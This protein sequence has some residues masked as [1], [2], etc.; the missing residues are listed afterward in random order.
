MN[1]NNPSHHPQHP[2][3]ARLAE[4]ASGFIDQTATPEEIDELDFLLRDSEANR[5]FF[6]QYMDVQAA[7]PEVLAET[8][9][10][11]TDARNPAFDWAST[12]AQ[13]AESRKT[14]GAI[15]IAGHGMEPP[16]RVSNLAPWL[17][18]IASLA[19]SCLFA[20]SF[21]LTRDINLVTTQTVR[22]SHTPEHRELVRLTSVADAELFDESVPAI[23]ASLKYGHEYALVT[24]I[25]SLTFPC[26]AEVI[27]EAPSVVEITD[28]M[29]LLIKA[30]KCS[31][32]APDGAEGFRVDTPDN[33]I[34][35]LGTRFAV[36]VS[37]AGRTDVHVVEGAAEISSLASPEND[38][39]RL[40]EQQALR[41]DGVKNTTIKFQPS[42]YRVMLP[43]RVVRYQCRGDNEPCAELRS[44]TVQREGKLIEYPVEDLIGIDVTY[45]R[46]SFLNRHV[47]WSDDIPLSDVRDA[48]QSDHSLITGLINIGG[49][50]QPLTE[51]PRLDSD[52]VSPDA[53]G[54]EGMAIQF[55]RPVRNDAGPD[56][57]LFEVQSVLDTP[58]GDPFHVSPL[59]FETGLRS[60]TISR[61]DISMK[62][63][64]AK[65]AAS[66]KLIDPDRRTLTLDALRDFQPD[67]YQPSVG[68]LILATGIDLSDLGY[69][70][71]QRVSG[72]FL[73]DALDNKL[74]IDPM[75]IAGLPELTNE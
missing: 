25:M 18:A 3:R 69:P 48:L 34:V 49:S 51:S 26:G 31:V 74:S 1:P 66:F 44:V 32:H 4:L 33:T 67:H 64:E 46:S 53:D 19:V 41:L 20:I 17:L 35:D 16:R 65:R 2:I 5:T 10:D 43:D 15:G 21:Y 39:K 13:Y 36:K 68:F 58:H 11:L 8:H 72:L 14:L 37:D 50:V 22:S 60:H 7:I 23:G 59:V 28:P 29:R 38:S 6:L 27:L 56:V 30:G 42:E 70:K 71:G 40:N 54:T 75:F 45:F 63:P 62:S 9:D 24:G 52:A 61:Y 73:Q 12:L 57:V 47:A 55:A